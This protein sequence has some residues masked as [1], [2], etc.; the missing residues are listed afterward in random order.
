MWKNTVETGG[1]QTA[2]RRMCIACWTPKAT[3]THSEYIKLIDFPMQ[4]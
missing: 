4:Q 2:I 3:H 1:P